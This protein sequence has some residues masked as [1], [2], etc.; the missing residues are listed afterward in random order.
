MVVIAYP[1]PGHVV[2]LGA[3]TFDGKSL[4]PKIAYSH[5]NMALGS[6]LYISRVEVPSTAPVLIFSTRSAEL[7]DECTLVKEVASMV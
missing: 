5:Q 1:R 4:V 7:A 3:H 2:G 6:Q